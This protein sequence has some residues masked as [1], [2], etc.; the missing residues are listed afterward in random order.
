MD[1]TGVNDEVDH[2]PAR[3]RGN[4]QVEVIFRGSDKG[5]GIGV[6]ESK[7]LGFG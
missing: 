5:G 4:W 6:E 7:I 2:A 3:A 1:D